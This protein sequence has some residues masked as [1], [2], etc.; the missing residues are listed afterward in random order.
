MAEGTGGSWARQS[1]PQS[2][3]DGSMSRGGDFGSESDPRSNRTIF[4]LCCCVFECDLLLHSLHD[5]WICHWFLVWTAH[6]ST[7]GHSQQ[8][9]RDSAVVADV[10][11]DFDLAFIHA[12]VGKAVLG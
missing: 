2:W 7:N 4:E 5:F 1:S 9:I 6:H 8:A 12:N 11:F 3:R 10:A